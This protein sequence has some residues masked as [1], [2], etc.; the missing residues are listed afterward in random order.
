MDLLKQ[1][2]VE[3]QP[4]IFAREGAPGTGEGRE[5]MV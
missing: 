1:S 3:L 4:Q 5:D 2:S